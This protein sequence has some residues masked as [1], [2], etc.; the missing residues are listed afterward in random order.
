MEALA[1]AMG[2]ADATEHI[3]ASTYTFQ[4]PA[5]DDKGGDGDTGDVVVIGDNI[6]GINYKLA[7]CCNP[8]YGDD[9]FG[10]ISSEGVIK[11]HRSDCPNAAH[12]KARYPYRLIRT[13]W[14]GKVG[15]E[16]GAAL[17]VVGKDDIVV[18]ALLAILARGHLLLE[19]I[20]GVGKTTLAL[21]LAK[22][23]ACRF[24]RI[25]FTPWKKH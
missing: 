2:A 19:D 12:I 1:K 11:I 9:V 4:N 16:F 20:P 7:K 25:Q 5:D 21:A 3:S 18:K 10:F 13:R 8:I 6:K 23:M 14:S 22:S 24:G 15:A 17:R